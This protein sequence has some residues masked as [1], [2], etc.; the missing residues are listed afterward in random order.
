VAAL[1]EGHRS[2]KI[3]SKDEALVDFKKMSLKIVEVIVF[4]VKSAPLAALA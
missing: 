2:A 3:F 1:F 4:G